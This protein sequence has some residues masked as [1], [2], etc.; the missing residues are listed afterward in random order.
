MNFRHGRCQGGGDMCASFGCFA[1]G[2]ASLDAFADCAPGH[3][4]AKVVSV[5]LGRVEAVGI[6]ILD[7]NARVRR[8]GIGRLLLPC[9]DEM[10]SG[11]MYP[12]FT[13]LLGRCICANAQG[14]CCRTALGL[15][16]I[17]LAAHV[18][19]GADGEARPRMR[20]ALLRALS[21]IYQP[22]SIGAN[23]EASTAS[24]R[25]SSAA[26]SPSSALSISLGLVLVPT[27]VW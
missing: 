26:S 8:M 23:V 19:F 5:D 10:H 18:C 12:C 4:P 20:R 22:R 24:L 27:P 2:R 1:A 21:C 9:W 25:A 13:R 16:E 15:P 14:A 7:R 3:T 11:T 17:G 6:D